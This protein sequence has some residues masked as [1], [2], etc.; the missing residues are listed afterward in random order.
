ML[1][2]IRLVK[3]NTRALPLQ[4][5]FYT[6]CGLVFLALIASNASKNLDKHHVR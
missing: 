4:I 5:A 6:K 2:N 1:T 3:A